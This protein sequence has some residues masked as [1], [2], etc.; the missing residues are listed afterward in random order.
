MIRSAAGREAQVRPHR[1]LAPRPLR[2][3]DHISISS[4]N[5]VHGARGHRVPQRIR[6]HLCRPTT[7]PCLSPRTWCRRSLEGRQLP[8]L[9]GNALM[10]SSTTSRS[11]PCTIWSISSAPKPETAEPGEGPSAGRSCCRT[12]LLPRLEE[13]RAPSH[14]GAEPLATPGVG[15]IDFVRAQTRRPPNRATSAGGPYC[16]TLPRLEIGQAL[17]LPRGWAACSS[18]TRHLSLHLHC[19]FT[20][21]SRWLL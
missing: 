13:W 15:M 1:P 16:R 14:I 9:T 11:S 18:D 6:G 5:R 19:T 21:A 3:C 20:K 7:A 8:E 12:G 17:A 4:K 2:R 10:P